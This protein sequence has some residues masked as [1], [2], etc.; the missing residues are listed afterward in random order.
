MS[1]CLTDDT[2]AALFE[3]RLSSAER[4][5]VESHLDDC[6][7]CRVLAGE[8]ATTTLPPDAEADTYASLTDLSCHSAWQPPPEIEEFRL[9]RQVGK[10][11][12]GLVFQAWDQKLGR[13]V[14]IKLLRRSEPDRDSRERLLIEARAIAR[15]NHPSVVVVHRTGEVKDHPF[16]VSEFVDGRSLALVPKP[17]PWREVLR[18]GIAITRGLRAAHEAGVLHRDIKPANVMLSDKGEV[19][20]LDFGL[21]KMA[22]AMPSSTMPAA[23]A[24]PLDDAQTSLTRTGALIGT[25]RYMAPEI[26]RREPAT[27]RSDLYS[28]GSVLYELCAGHP[29]FAEDKMAALESAVLKRDP[30]PLSTVVADV[31]ARFAEQVMRCLCREPEQ[32]PVSADELLTALEQVLAESSRPLKRWRTLVSIA[33]VSVVLPLFGIGM[34]AWLPRWKSPKT[35]KVAMAAPTITVWRRSVAIL[36]FQNVTRNPETEWLSAAL[37]EMLRSELAASGQLRLASNEQVYQMIRDLELPAT[38]SLGADTLR[39]I[40]NYLDVDF[41]ITGSYVLQ[42]EGAAKSLRGLRL[43]YRLLDTFT[44]APLIETSEHEKTEDLFTLVSNTGIN[45]RT[46]LGMQAVEAS[47]RINLRT[48][49]PETVTAL[50]SYS[51]G[52]M[53]MRSMEYPKALERLEFA[54]KEAPASPKV[55]SA[56]AEISYLLGRTDE[57]RNAA[58][59]ALVYSGDMSHEEQLEIEV[60]YYKSTNDFPR[61]LKAQIDL[62]KLRPDNLEYRLTLANLQRDNS[63]PKASLETLKEIKNDFP[64]PIRDDPRIDLIAEVNYRALYNYPA[65]LQAAQFAATRGYNRGSSYIVARANLAQGYSY[66]SMGQYINAEIYLDKAG[67]QLQNLK[68]WHDA[69]WALL[70]SADAKLRTGRL[71]DALDSYRKQISFLK[72]HKIHLALTFAL[73]F[74]VPIELS[75]GNIE[76]ALKQCKIAQA[77]G[78]EYHFEVIKQQSIIEMGLIKIVTGDLSEAAKLVASAR[79]GVIVTDPLSMALMHIL[80][81]RFQYASGNLPDAKSKMKMAIDSLILANDLYRVNMGSNVISDAPLPPDPCRKL[82][83]RASAWRRA[84]CRSRK[85]FLALPPRLPISAMWER[86]ALTVAPPFLSGLRCLLGGEAVCSA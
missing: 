74:S 68:M 36:G 1:E 13:R 56:L 51:E 46:H 6:E 40:R 39:K 24:G 45:L 25:P 77:L 20:I 18:I 42:G 22:T 11:H 54:A 23:D 83:P 60:A 62:S 72:E 9:I 49:I 84:A 34:K 64:A 63:D 8:L 70:G 12:T 78:N 73:L 85:P 28:L 33:L 44:G 86:S 15:L 50:R 27:M 19:K 37:S 80:E 16:I 14:A 30:A 55:Q 10:G 21:A 65:S 47:K 58:Y 71:S 67:T 53:A 82:I 57:Q 38:S 2:L 75:M 61:A 26:W 79:L 17:L 48:K 81:G 35:Q 76:T 69:S 32:R 52:L 59:S 31:D 29:A 3:R 41:I 43:D 4:A 5:D 66:K 7:S